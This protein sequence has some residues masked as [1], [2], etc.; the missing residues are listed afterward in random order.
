MTPASIASDVGSA[1]PATLLRGHLPQFAE[2][3]LAFLVRCAAEHGDIVPLRFGPKRFWFLSDPELVGE[4]L[5]NRASSFKKN[6]AMRRLQAIF[7][8]GLLISDG[9]EHD[10]RMHLLRPA[11]SSTAIVN[12][13]ATMA[14][15]STRTF[16]GWTDGRRIDLFAEFS[17]LTI[18]ILA[19]ALFGVDLKERAARILEAFNQFVVFMDRRFLQLAPPPLFVPTPENRKVAPALSLLRDEAARIV[20][21]R[22]NVPPEGDGLL[23]HLMGADQTSLKQLRSDVTILLW[24]GSET[25]ANTMTFVCHLLARHPHV[26]DAVRREVRQVLG[27]RAVDAA[28]IP[29]M[30]FMRQV[31]QESLRLFPPGWLISREAAE[32]VVLGGRLAL[33]RGDM[34]ATSAYI[35]QRDPRWFEEPLAFR[36]ERFAPDAPRP[37]PHTYFPFGAGARGCTGQ[38]F[39]QL[40]LSIVLPTLIQRFDLEIDATGEPEL[41]PQLTLR[42]KHRI[43]AVVRRR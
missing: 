34:V 11:L 21:A 38:A 42:P 3:K 20:A 19:Q 14:A 40:E 37:L 30:P 33:R 2:N 28:D 43:E 22:R 29:R 9:A 5:V 27:N 1:P 31:I 36:P 25:S 8:D 32:D 7:G 16:D 24:V 26:L 17:R 35:I 13:A 6:V 15:M 12:Y 18:T 39:G 4:F 10:R 41:W 23:L